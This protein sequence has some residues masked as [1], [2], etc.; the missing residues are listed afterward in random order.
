MADRRTKP[1]RKIV[2]ISLTVSVPDW[3]KAAQ[4]RK[5]VRSRLTHLSTEG[6]CRPGTFDELE[7]K[8]LRV[9]KLKPA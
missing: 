2:S 9:R 5:E 6:F 7:H 8:D 4:A 1:R 3:V